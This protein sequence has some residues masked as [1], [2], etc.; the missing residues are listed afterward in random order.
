MEISFD[1]KI[2]KSLQDPASTFTSLHVVFSR[3]RPLSVTLYSSAA[4]PSRAAPTTPNPTPC[5][6]IRPSAALP[7]A[8]VAAALALEVALP[9]PADAE[10]A[11]ALAEAEAL[12]MA[13]ETEDEAAEALLPVALALAVAAAVPPLELPLVAGEVEFAVQPAEAGCYKRKHR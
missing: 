3:P 9:W 5:T 7:A 8:D 12:L 13:E 2:S 1:S 6:L 11:A 10:D 4:S